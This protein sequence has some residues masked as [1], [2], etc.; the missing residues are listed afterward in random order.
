MDIFGGGGVIHPTATVI[1]FIELLILPKQNYS[2]N[3]GL[4]C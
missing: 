4:I 1:I 2:R 3:L